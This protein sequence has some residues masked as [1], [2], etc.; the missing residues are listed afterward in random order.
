MYPKNLKEF[1][2]TNEALRRDATP[3]YLNVYP[4]VHVFGIPTTFPSLGTLVSMHVANNILAT[5]LCTCTCIYKMIHD[6]QTR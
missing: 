6:S 1:D 2:S 4:S 5:K 3:I